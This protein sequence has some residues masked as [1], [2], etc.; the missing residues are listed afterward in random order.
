PPAQPPA[1]SER[2]DKTPVS[3]PG[4]SEAQNLRA[5]AVALFSQPISLAATSDARS[6]CLDSAALRSPSKGMASSERAETRCSF[7]NPRRD[8]Q[9]Q[10]HWALRCRL[11]ELD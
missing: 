6:I 4:P 2:P 5:D 7:H 10:E 3:D 1:P 11:G 9:L 8:P